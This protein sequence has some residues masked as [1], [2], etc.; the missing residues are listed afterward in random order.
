VS[1]NL[2]RALT[3]RRPS[4][5]RPAAGTRQ[6]AS[7]LAP[8]GRSAGLQPALGVRSHPTLGVLESLTTCGRAKPTSCRRSNNP[9]SFA[10]HWRKR[11]TGLASEYD[12]DYFVR[13]RAV[14]LPLSARPSV[15][16][17][18]EKQWTQ[19]HELPAGKC[20]ARGADSP[21]RG[22]NMGFGSALFHGRNTLWAVVQAVNGLASMPSRSGP[23]P[24]LSE[25]SGARLSPST[26]RSQF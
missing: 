4:G 11:A 10:G 1:R 8:A 25:N 24:S 22:E 23:S 16:T 18:G 14:R 5:L 9:A 7:V 17:F 6:A 26:S 13:D 19:K 3:Q 20:A 2:R 15:Q 21:S 12:P